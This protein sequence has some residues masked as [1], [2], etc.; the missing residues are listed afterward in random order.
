[1]LIKTGI[2]NSTPQFLEY[3]YSIL[4]DE[5]K[6]VKIKPQVGHDLSTFKLQDFSDWVG[7][8]E[9]ASITMDNGDVL[10]IS[11]FHNDQYY[12][13]INKNN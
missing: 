1:M 2:K 9:T 11:F 6:D 4:E 13:T 5:Y 8:R 10:E 3:I 7:A 12:Y